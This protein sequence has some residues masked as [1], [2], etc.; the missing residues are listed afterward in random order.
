MPVLA[1]SWNPACTPEAAEA[2]GV[3]SAMAQPTPETVAVRSEPDRI[4]ATEL[5]GRCRP[6]TYAWIS[7][8]V[9]TAGPA[10]TAAWLPVAAWLPGVGRVLAAAAPGAEIRPA[11]S[12]TAGSAPASMTVSVRADL[13]RTMRVRA[14]ENLNC[15]TVLSPRRYRRE[16]LSA[17]SRRTGATGGSEKKSMRG[18]ARKTRQNMSIGERSRQ[19][20]Q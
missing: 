18:G 12:A 9:L 11:P 3:K 4:P 1:P 14:R 15:V 8:P 20:P 2:D 19:V 17:R 7:V 16:I 13:A 5:A 10:L 6:W